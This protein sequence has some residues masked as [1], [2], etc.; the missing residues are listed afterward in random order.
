[1]PM[2]SQSGNPAR[3]QG[4][5]SKAAATAFVAV[6]VEILSVVAWVAAFANP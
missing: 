3:Q 1:M 4:M 6:A 5:E 2:R